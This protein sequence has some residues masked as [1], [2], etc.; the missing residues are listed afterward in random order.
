[1]LID[2]KCFRLLNQRCTT[3]I[4]LKIRNFNDNPYTIIPLPVCDELCSTSVY[5]S[6]QADQS[7][8]SMARLIYHFRGPYSYSVIRSPTQSYRYN[9]RDRH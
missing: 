7:R 6:D 1:M 4:N 2:V 5:G 8:T 9:V 3:S